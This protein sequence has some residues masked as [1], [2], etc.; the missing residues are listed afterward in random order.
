MEWIV[1]LN[2]HH[3]F[4]SHNCGLQGNLWLGHVITQTVTQISFLAGGVLFIV[5]IT[6]IVDC[7]LLMYGRLLGGN[8]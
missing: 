1:K 8:R 5:V 3:L 7:V 2:L 4:H 6:R